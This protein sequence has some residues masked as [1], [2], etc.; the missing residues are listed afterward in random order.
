MSVVFGGQGLNLVTL[1]GDGP[2]I[3]Q[4]TLHREFESDEHN[5]EGS[6]NPMREGILGRI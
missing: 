4:S 2:V 6:T 3:L 5:E 1:T